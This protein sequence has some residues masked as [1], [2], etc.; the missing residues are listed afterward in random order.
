MYFIYICLGFLSGFEVPVVVAIG[1]QFPKE[2]LHRGIV[3]EV[4]RFLN[5][6]CP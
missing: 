6:N 2:A 1:F 5:K 3:P 4:V